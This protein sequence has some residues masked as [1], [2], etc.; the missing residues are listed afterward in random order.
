MGLNGTLSKFYDVSSFMIHEIFYKSFDAILRC[1]SVF[2]YCTCVY[3]IEI[4]QWKI[5]ES[6]HELRYFENHEI[7]IKHYAGGWNT[8][9]CV[10]HTVYALL[11]ILSFD[12]KS[13]TVNS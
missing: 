10:Y 9:F 1:S 13:K 11:L 4:Y 6:F 7:W 12:I 3:K 2:V 5:F 8:V